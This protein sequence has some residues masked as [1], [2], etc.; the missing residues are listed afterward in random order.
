MSVSPCLEVDLQALIKDIKGENKKERELV[1]AGKKVSKKNKKSAL[2]ECGV[3]PEAYIARDLIQRIV[4][5]RF[6][7]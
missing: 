2:A 1:G 5:P 6:L 7:R 4:Y 3:G